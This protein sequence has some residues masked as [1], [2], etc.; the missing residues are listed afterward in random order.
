MLEK[1]VKCVLQK[2]QNV[3]EHESLFSTTAIDLMS[4]LIR[5][6][7]L[8]VVIHSNVK[9]N[10]VFLGFRQLQGLL[11]LCSVCKFKNELKQ[12][13]ILFSWGV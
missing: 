9:V 5:D 2:N 11:L 1:L 10:I 4:C 7:L 3:I 8:S 13:D 12:A 6:I